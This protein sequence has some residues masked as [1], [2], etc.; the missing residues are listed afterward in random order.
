MPSNNLGKQINTERVPSIEGVSEGGNEKIPRQD[1]N[2]GGRENDKEDPDL[3]QSRYGKE[4]T[5]L[6]FVLDKNVHSVI[7][8]VANILKNNKHLNIMVCGAAG[9]G[10]T[11]FVKLF[12]SKFN[13]SKAEE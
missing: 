9:I 2:R 5:Y 1:F 3:S 8:Q 7:Q 4:H 13:K 11:Q 6:W 10:K 12:M